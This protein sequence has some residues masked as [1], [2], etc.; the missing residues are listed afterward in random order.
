M[1]TLFFVAI[2]LELLI[3]PE[4]NAGTALGLFVGKTV[5]LKVVRAMQ[6]MRT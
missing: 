5:T 1:P 2:F 4:F 6:Y 3:S